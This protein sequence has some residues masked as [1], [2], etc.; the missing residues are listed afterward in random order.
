M[1][2][3]LS[4]VSFHSRIVPAKEHVTF[5]FTFSVPKHLIERTRITT[6]VLVCA[7]ERRRRAD[8]GVRHFESCG[9]VV[10]R[11]VLGSLSQCANEGAKV[12]LL[13]LACCYAGRKV[14][15]GMNAVGDDKPRGSVCIRGDEFGR[16]KQ[17][18]THEE[19]V[20]NMPTKNQ[21]EAKGEGGLARRTNGSYAP[22]QQ[23]A[24]ICSQPVKL[25]T[26]SPYH[27]SLGCRRAR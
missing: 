16:D 19:V 7:I 24:T 21:T 6:S 15:Q 2:A 10:C 26:T 22:P 18:S 23:R 1:S 20:D 3:K 12:E 27:A 11:C 4:S 17:T 13:S 8:P 5:Q 9:Q 25:S 14:L